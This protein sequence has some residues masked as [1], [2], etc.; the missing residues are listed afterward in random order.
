MSTSLLTRLS[1]TGLLVLLGMSVACT[2]G[3]NSS[4]PRSPSAGEGKS[5]PARVSDACPLVALKVSYDGDPQVKLDMAGPGATVCFKPGTYRLGARESLHPLPGQTL[6]FLPGAVLS[7]SEEVSNWVHQGL[8]WSSTGHDRDL[9]GAPWLPDP[10]LMCPEAPTACIYEDVFLDG[11]PLHH[12]Q[13][14]SALDEPQEVFFD[15]PMGTIYLSTDPS[16]RPVE[17]TVAG[18]GISS[19]TTDV[20]TDNVTIRGATIE[21]FAYAGIYT[22]ADGWTV[23]DS[24]IRYNHG[25][26]IGIFGGIGHVIQN[27]R[28]HHNGMIGMTAQHVDD[29][30]IKGNEFDHNNYLHTGP[31]TGGYHEGS[32][33]ILESNEVMFRNNW[34]HDNVGDGLWF[35]WDNYDVLIENNLLESNTRNGLHYEA[36]FDATVRFNTIRDNGTWDSQSAGI[37]NSTS[38]NIEYYGNRIEHNLIRPI[39]ILWGD[40]GF[41]PLLGE[42]QS[43]N[44][45]FHDNVIVLGDNDQSWV[46]ASLDQDPRVFDSN[47]RFQSNTYHAAARGGDWWRWDSG[48]LSWT[49]WQ[50]RGFDTA[51][52]YLSP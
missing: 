29:F 33:K 50:T 49:Q 41:N 15:K 18:F 5:S 36:S 34:S 11:R 24:D 20:V 46:G 32:V 38:K 52:S 51:G 44:L 37:L 14:L 6:I 35:D 19:P 12:V 25:G 9:S 4:A 10:A 1:S 13:T 16:N 26:G 48:S 22:E 23:E 27:S 3:P 42:R 2:S 45:Y 39:V 43:A 21:H 47:N 8:Y 28:V 40:R 30:T 17:M 7:G 31:T